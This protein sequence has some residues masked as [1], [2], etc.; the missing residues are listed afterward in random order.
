V[1]KKGQIPK[2]VRT[3]LHTRSDHCCEICGKWG[4]NAHHR[5][6]R[7]QGGKDVLSNLMLLCGSG[8]TG[9]HGYV[10]E[11]P[12]EGRDKGWCVW[13]H[14]KPAEVPVLYRGQLVS[15]GDDGHVYVL[16]SNTRKVRGNNGASLL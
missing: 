14:Q 11:H 13:S 9:C 8:T 5:K 15:L 3:A 4:N 12:A 7:S 2:A 1:T 10:T 16:P 6:N